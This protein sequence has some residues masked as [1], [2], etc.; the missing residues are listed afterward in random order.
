MP[1]IPSATKIAQPEELY[2]PGVYKG[3]AHDQDQREAHQ[4]EDVYET[5]SKGTEVAIH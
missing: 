5:K 1:E 3:V 4:P 2:L